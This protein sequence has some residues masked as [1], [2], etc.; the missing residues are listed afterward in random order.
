MHIRFNGLIMK[1]AAILHFPSFW[2]ILILSILNVK[3]T[4]SNDIK[5]NRSLSTFDYECPCSEYMTDSLTNSSSSSNSNSSKTN[6]RPWMAFIKILG[7]N[8]KKMAVCGGSL[9]TDRFVLTAAHCVCNGPKSCMGK[10]FFTYD[11]IKNNHGYN[12]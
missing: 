8:K 7:E 4:I 5:S 2:T 6:G 9:L 10:Y 1:Y 11:F 3:R 12:E